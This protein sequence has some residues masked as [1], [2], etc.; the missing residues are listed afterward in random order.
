MLPVR[1]TDVGITGTIGTMSSAA[2][3]TAGRGTSRRAEILD[4]FVR[5]VAQRGYDGT[6]LADV[7]AEVGISKGTIVHHFTSK[8]RML[9][10]HHEAYMRRRLAE[11]KLCLASLHT[12]AEQLAGLIF[13]GILYQ[14]ADR[15]PTVAFQRETVRFRDDDVMTESQR[16]RREYL[17]MIADIVKR[18]M[19]D[20]TFRQDDPRLVALTLF[21]PLQWA[22]TWYDPDGRNTPE[23][24]A[25]TIISVCLGGLIADRND[26][27][28]LDDGGHLPTLIRAIVQSTAPQSVA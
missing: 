18:G 8:D 20:G 4:T 10:E 7:A 13:A 11:A 15:W 6:N 16:L 3:H 26:L 21:G 23:E 12:P 1:S 25:A 2:P 9:A 24:V 27:T 14:Q 22:W 17:E 19:D 28:T 5:L